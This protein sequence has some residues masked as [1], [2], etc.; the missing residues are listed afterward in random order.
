MFVDSRFHVAVRPVAEY[1]VPELARLA[2]EAVLG[3]APAE[4]TL[5][6]LA[7][8]EAAAAAAAARRDEGG[9]GDGAE[10]AGAAAAALTPL[11]EACARVSAL[12]VEYL[13]GAS[14]AWRAHV[15][16]ARSAVRVEAARLRREANEANRVRELYLA[17]DPALVEREYRTEMARL[18]ARLEGALD[19]IRARPAP[20]TARPADLREASDRLR[21]VFAAAYGTAPTPHLL[22]VKAAFEREVDRVQSVVL[23]EFCRAM[24]ALL[25]EDARERG[26]DECRDA[27]AAR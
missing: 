11:R 1:R 13:Q 12:L 18:S 10:A 7:E 25:R 17:R 14:S 8:E 26:R 22:G 19:A 21:D 2:H 9:D 23:V 15:A 4:P 27:G 24:R 3:D 16:H 20:P 6:A 5:A